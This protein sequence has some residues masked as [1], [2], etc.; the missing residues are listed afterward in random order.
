MSGYCLLE[1]CCFLKGN[2]GI[3]D[4]GETGGREVL[5]MVR[6]ETVF[7]LDHMR[8]ESTRINKNRSAKTEIDEQILVISISR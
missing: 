1:L 3:I 7:G 4:L 2:G 5:E 6:E 8:E